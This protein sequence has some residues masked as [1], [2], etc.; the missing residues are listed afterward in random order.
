M[1]FDIY[2][3]D[4]S[5][6]LQ[7]MNGRKRNLLDKEE[8]NKYTI[9]PQNPIPEVVGQ[10]TW[11]SNY[12]LTFWMPIMGVGAFTAYLQLVKMCYGEKEFA[13]PSVPYLAMM[14]GVSETTARKYIIELQELGFINVIQVFD[15]KRNI[16]KPNLY[17]LSRTIPYLTDKQLE[18]LPM[19]LQ[20]EHAKFVE[21]T[22]KRSI[23]E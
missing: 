11:I 2:N 10:K 4:F 5:Y 19:K 7:L 1:E 16:N 12:V 20:D 6:S 17:L 9:N 21:K 13:Y 8:L 23:F 22:K 15:T 3:P 14:M 18:K